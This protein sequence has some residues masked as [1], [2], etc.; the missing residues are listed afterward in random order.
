[1]NGW[2]VAL[3]RRDPERLVRRGCRQRFS[4]W[5]FG[6]DC[7]GIGVF[8]DPPEEGLPDA[9]VFSGAPILIQGWQKW[10]LWR[11]SLRW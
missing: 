8:R 11:R 3:N 2:V 1:M 7:P 9:E 6:E 4:G 5:F 10:L